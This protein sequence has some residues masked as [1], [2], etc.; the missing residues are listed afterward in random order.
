VNARR[1][2]PQRASESFVITVRAKPRASVSALEQ[3]A[4]G[5]WVA[6]LQSSPVDGKANTEL[7]A[8]V[9]KHFGCAR[10]CVSVISG[11]TARLKL[12]RI[13]GTTISQANGAA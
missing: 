9:A 4:T 2:K 12:V 11:A 5:T 13:S 3:E 7:V 6:R 10:S 1:T 8:L